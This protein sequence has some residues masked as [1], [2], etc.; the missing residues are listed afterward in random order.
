MWMKL[1]IQS[2]LIQFFCFCSALFLFFSFIFFVNSL[3]LM[4]RSFPSGEYTFIRIVV[5]SPITDLLLFYAS[6]IFIF[7][8]TFLDRVWI[9]RREWAFAFFFPL[10]LSLVTFAF[11][12][13]SIGKVLLAV[14]SLLCFFGIVT[15][16]DSTFWWET[17][18][19]ERFVN[20]IAYL[21]GIFVIIEIISLFFW[22][23]NPFFGFEGFWRF[24]LEMS[25]VET[26]LFHIPYF[27]SPFLTFIFLFA[28]FLISFYQLVCRRINFHIHVFGRKFDVGKLEDLD[29]K[30][31]FLGF[32]EKKRQSILVLFLSVLLSLVYGIYTYFP[33]FCGENFLIGVDT[34]HYIEYLEVMQAKDFHSAI[35]YSFYNLSDRWLSV[36]TLYAFSTIFNLSPFT[37]SQ[38]CPMVLGPLLVLSTYFFMRKAGFSESLCVL[39]GLFLSFSSIYIMGLCFAFLSNMMAWIFLLIFSGFFVQ[40][41]VSSS[42]FSFVMASIALI[43]VLFMHV[44]TWS[45]VMFVLICFLGFLFI[46]K[47]RIIRSDV[48]LKYFSGIV[49]FNLVV[50]FVRQFLIGLGGFSARM[51]QGGAQAW[52][53]PLFVLTFWESFSKSFIRDFLV[54][55]FMLFL[56]F[57]GF[58]VLILDKRENNPSHLFLKFWVASP[59]V[60]Y[61]FANDT[62]RTRILYVLPFQI[63]GAVGMLYL[64][65]TMNCKFKGFFG[66]LF[67]FSVFLFFLLVNVN[68]GMRSASIISNANF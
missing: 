63:L 57:V 24:L 7:F 49:V 5:F 12:L 40:T 25:L 37:V 18:S 22:F 52:L 17:S 4:Y 29:L 61:L 11:Q 64:F 9:H 27:L 67:V 50:E 20:V 6:S 46:R 53:S 65:F 58:L 16:P 47:V 8:F 23:V 28:W 66:K 14:S 35:A 13:F 39:A 26:H 19:R 54:N 32:L 30:F 45:L 42:R 68:F 38:Y 48:G 33:L 55:P 1:E 43:A 56:S 15:N 60:L 3:N 21:S 34:P 36:S 59:S 2:V 10:L 44:Y 31:L 41:L 51:V 62:A